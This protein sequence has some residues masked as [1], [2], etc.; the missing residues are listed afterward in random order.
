MTTEFLYQIFFVILQELDNYG[1]HIKFLK[2]FIF[3]LKLD[4]KDDKIVQ[5]VMKLRFVVK[6]QTDERTD[7]WR[8]RSAR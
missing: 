1:F 4:F 7:K 3:H 6:N 2:D 8:Y 5:Y